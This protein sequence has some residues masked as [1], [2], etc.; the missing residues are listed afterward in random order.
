MNAAQAIQRKIKKEHVT[1]TKESLLKSI[2]ES[3]YITI[4]KLLKYGNSNNELVMSLI[5]ELEAQGEIF[6][7]DDKIIAVSPQITLSLIGL[8]FF[9]TVILEHLIG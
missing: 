2:R 1:P 5:T 7:F 6:V 3:K 4:S 8:L 9:G